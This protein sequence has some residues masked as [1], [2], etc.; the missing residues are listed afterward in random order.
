MV[1]GVGHVAQGTGC[2]ACSAGRGAC[3]AGGAGRGT[4]PLIVSAVC[5]TLAL[6]ENNSQLTQTAH[7]S[8]ILKHVYSTVCDFKGQS[9]LGTVHSIL[10]LTTTVSTAQSAMGNVQFPFDM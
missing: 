10:R 9:A 8:Q 1:R 6:A 4:L 5:R 7:L 2:G 3:S